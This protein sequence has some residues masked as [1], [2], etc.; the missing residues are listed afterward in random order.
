MICVEKRA[1]CGKGHVIAKT[2]LLSEGNLVILLFLAGLRQ[3]IAG[4]KAFV[5]IEEVF[6]FTMIHAPLRIMIHRFLIGNLHE[7]LCAVP[8]VIPGTVVL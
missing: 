6:N 4:V 8:T 2:Y 3:N 1:H 5:H 7:G